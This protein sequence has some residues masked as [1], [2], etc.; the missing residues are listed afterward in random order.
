MNM[1]L[2]QDC[3][4]KNDR[5]NTFYSDVLK[6]LAAYPKKL[7]SKYFYDKTGDQLFQQIMA[8]PEYYLTNCEL[9][10]FQNKTEELTKAISNINES[11]D[12]IEL[13]A[14]DAM[15]S[16]YLLKKLVDKGTDF[17][18]M[19]I[20]I[21]GNI[22]SVLQENLNKKLP[23]LK[24]LPLQ[25]E[26]FDMLDKATAISKRKKVVLF[27]GGNIGNM[28]IEEAVHFCSEVKR[29][30]NSGDLFLVGF[31]L[32]KNPNTILAAYNDPAGITASFNLNLLTRINREL[33]ADFDEK[34]FQHY[35]T[36]D[37]V[38][39]ACRSFL[40]SLCDQEVRVDNHLF[41]FKENELIDM[42]VSQKFSEQDIKKLAGDSGFHILTEIKDAK[43]WFVDS[44]WMV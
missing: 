16:S 39:G 4:L 12:L 30:L 25:G 36:Y 34:Q 15:K 32:K 38:S 11:F 35:Q 2:K 28:E 41:H 8:M 5:A 19:P 9:D 24:I 43:N 6:G 22:L 13:G 3:Y 23:E 37:P 17:T 10:I 1:Q 44:I 26:Y 40:V 21:S 29:K 33:N 27:L 7:S 14:G 18:Y 42:E 31:D 20:D